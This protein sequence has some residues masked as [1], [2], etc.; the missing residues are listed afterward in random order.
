MAPADPEP[1]M[2][3]KVIPIRKPV[4]VSPRHPSLHGKTPTADRPLTITLDRLQCELIASLLDL[5]KHSAIN[6]QAADAAIE[7]LMGGKP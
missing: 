4:A 5:A 7:F 1:A 2:T 6:N 3:G